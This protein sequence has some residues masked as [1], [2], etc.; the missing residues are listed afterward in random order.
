MPTE[1]RGAPRTACHGAFSH[2]RP[3]RQVD[4]REWCRQ[5][6]RGT[7]RKVR[8]PPVSGFKLLPNGFEMNI[9]R[10]PRAWARDVH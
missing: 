2:H 5:Q 8:R 10:A 1:Y 9:M 4:L 6:R 7:S 3:G